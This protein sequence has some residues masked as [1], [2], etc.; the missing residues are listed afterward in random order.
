MT[1]S[2]ARPILS[3]G[4]CRATKRIMDVAEHT[5]EGHLLKP[6]HILALARFSRIAS[7]SDLEEERYGLL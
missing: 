2:A 5:P 1:A 6:A 3:C 7:T 4:R